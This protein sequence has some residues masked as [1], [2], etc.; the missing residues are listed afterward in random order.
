MRRQRR[1]WDVLAII[2]LTIGALFILLPLAWLL[3]TAFKNAIVANAVPPQ[4][5]SPITFSNFHTLVKDQFYG[6]LGH[7]AILTSLTTAIAMILGTPAGYAFA[8]AEVPGRR[9]ISGVLVASYITPPVVTIIPLF[10]IFT[11][12]GLVNTYPGLVLAYQTG[13]LPF[14]IWMSRSFFLDVPREVDEAAWVDGCTKLGAFRR[15]ILP[16]ALPGLTTVAILVALAAWGEYFGA[17]ILTGPQTVTAPIAIYSYVGVLSNNWGAM[18]AGGLVV[19]LPMLA[20]AM[21]AQ[22]GLLRG[23]ALGAVKE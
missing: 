2:I 23:L 15:V 22:R 11:N 13:I 4:F 19:I 18:A 9:L 16:L 21:F 5:I 20:V 14:T 3:S 17:L 1:L 12:V 7:S 10:I 6:A 8:R